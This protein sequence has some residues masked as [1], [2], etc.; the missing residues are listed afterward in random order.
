M[1]LRRHFDDFG[2][3]G[4]AVSRVFNWYCARRPD[5][6]T[7]WFHASEV[8]VINRWGQLNEPAKWLDAKLRA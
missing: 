4:W 3:N 8:P 7:I 6:E 2:W 5:R 1:M